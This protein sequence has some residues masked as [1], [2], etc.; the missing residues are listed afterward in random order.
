[1]VSLKEKI[2]NSDLF[3]VL[4]TKYYLDSLKTNKENIPYQVETAKKF[5]KPTLLIIDKS[6]SKSE[7][8]ELEGYFHTHNVV[9]EMIVDLKDLSSWDEIRVELER[10]V[11]KYMTKEEDIRKK[12]SDPSDKVDKCRTK[13]SS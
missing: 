1:M 4:G 2:V 12:E 13:E 7:I 11:E 10:L 9:K 8:I 3:I 6:L 5:N